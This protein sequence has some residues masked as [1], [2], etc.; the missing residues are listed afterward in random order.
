M[1]RTWK[2]RD[3]DGVRSGGAFQFERLAVR[4]TRWRVIL[5][6]AGVA[7]YA[8]GLVATL[9]A[10]VIVPDDRDAVGTVWKGEAALPMGFAAG[11]S[12]QPL[13][14]LVRFGLAERIRIRGPETAIDGRAVLRPGH[15]RLTA[16]DGVASTR[17]VSAIAPGLPFVCDTDMRVAVAELA[18]RGAPA[19][20]GG[21]RTGP[22]SCQPRGGGAP[23]PVPTLAGAF[24]ADGEATTLTLTRDGGSEPL[25][26]ARVTPRGAMTLAVEPAG[27]GILPGVTVPLALETTL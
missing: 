3:G 11:W 2:I 22:G 4:V 10:E 15:V 1:L 9:P 25:A 16:L 23:S 6:G 12:V 26:R 7:A 27:I 19:G 14:S 24:T 21:F 5:A 13:Q 8:L 17:L 20:E 18:L